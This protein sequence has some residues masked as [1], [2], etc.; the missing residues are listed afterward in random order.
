MDYSKFDLSSIARV[1]YQDW[2]DKVNFAAKPYLEA[3]AT[4]TTID[5]MYFCDSGSS[6]VA[7]FLSNSGHW[8]G[9]T[10]RE[11][12]KELKMRIK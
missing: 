6:I 5:D 2:G 4:L 1:I 3:M 9:P 7:Y 8:T 12:K 11:I 10:A